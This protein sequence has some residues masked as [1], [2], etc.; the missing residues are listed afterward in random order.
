[1]QEGANYITK[2]LDVVGWTSAEA[3]CLTGGLGPA[4][5]RWLHLPTVTAKGTALDGALALAARAAGV[6]R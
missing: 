3:L 6:A 2:A 4:Y 5:A 1:M